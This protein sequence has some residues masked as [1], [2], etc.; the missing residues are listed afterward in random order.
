V[1]TL[2]QLARSLLPS[3][4]FKK[5]KPYQ[6]LDI[7]SDFKYFALISLSLISYQLF[8]VISYYPITE[9]WFSEFAHLIRAGYIPYKDFHLLISPL[10]P[11]T[12]ALIQ[13]IFGEHLIILRLIGMVI[14]VSIAIS[15]YLILKRLFTRSIAV[16]ASVMATIYYQSGNAY[17]GY[18]FTQFLTL[19]LLLGAM[20]LIETMS[21]EFD[22][23]TKV[24]TKSYSLFFSGLFFSLALLTKHSNAGIVILTMFLVTMPLSFIYL[25]FYRSFKLLLQ[26]STGFIVPLT[27]M[28]I[29]L[30]A[31]GVLNALIQDIFIN[32]QQAKGGSNVIF[33]NSVIKTLSTADLHIISCTKLFLYAA[34][35]W[36]LLKKISTC[37]LFR[38]TS[39]ECFF[40]NKTVHNSILYA[41]IFTLILLLIMAYIY[42][43]GS[44]Y[45]GLNIVTKI[46][47][48]ILVTNIT[49]SLRVYILGSIIACVL[50]IINPTSF[51]V[52][53]FLLSIFG[54]GLSF[55]NGSSAG[56][57]EISAFLGY[58]VSVGILFTLFTKVRFGLLVPL[59]ISFSIASVQI[60][61]KF[62]SPYYWWSVI[63]P[64]IRALNC[65]NSEGLFKGICVPADQYKKMEQIANEVRKHSS[66][67]EIYVYPHMPIFY[68]MTEK[69]PYRGAVVS[70]FDFMSDDQAKVLAHELLEKPPSMLI[71]AD[72]PDEVATAHEQL[73]R[74]GRLSGQRDIIA[75]IHKLVADRTICR[76]R[77]IKN[78][79]GLDIDLYIRTEKTT[80]KDVKN[81]CESVKKST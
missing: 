36:I 7:R 17:I 49:N 57:S 34:F 35:V 13:T 76:L 39:K 66:E 73:F 42:L 79:N 50:L 19:Y 16:I 43:A 3:F 62:S 65:A 28:F 14:T 40:L 30:G 48:T 53:L 72:L 33:Y 68:E 1:E 2:M 45:T 74:G 24:E 32:A 77:K 59:F 10:Y 15:T 5:D 18:D 26:I 9:G 51:H 4:I 63:T 64:D 56:L 71:I 23:A 31:H 21:A 22:T 75:S 55:G 29:W 61:S 81:Y 8:Y 27:I 47:Q 67:N 58:G 37:T 80:D 78:L 41:T 52:Y 70:W 12:L 11:L 46:G 54:L 38:I 6:L 60:S 69:I 44:E 25:G 20:F